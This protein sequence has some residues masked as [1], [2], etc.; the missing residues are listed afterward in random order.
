MS[1]KV[2]DLETQTKKEYKRKATPFCKENYIVARGWKNEGDA[3]C[4]HSYFNSA[5]E[6]TDMVIEDHIDCL[7]GHN[8]KFDMLWSWEEQ[9]IRDFITRGG[10]IWC[11]QYAEYLLRAHIK[12]YHMNSMDEIVSK[13]GGQLK[14]GGPKDLWE[15][16]YNTSEIPKDM[17]ID[18]LVGTEEEQRNGGDIGNT[19][20]IYLGQ[21]KLAKELNMMQIIEDRMDGLLATTEMEYNGLYVDVDEARSRTVVLHN[22]KLELEKALNEY[23]PKFED[24]EMVF[25]WN[26]PVHKSC[27]MFGGT[28]KYKKQAPYLNDDGEWARKK[29]T[30]DVYVM[31]DETIPSPPA[32]F[33][34]DGSP[35]FHEGAVIFKSGKKKGLCK[36]KKLKVDGELK[37]KY[38]EFKVSLK[39]YTEPN[40]AWQTASVDANGAPLYSMDAD[41]VEALQNRDIPFVK[42]YVSLSKLDK[43][44][45]YYVKLD[46]KGEPVGM[47]TCVHRDSHIIHHKINHTSTVTG[48][49]SS[50]DPNLQNIPRGDKSEIKRIFTSRFGSEGV[51]MECDYSQLEVVVQGVLSGDENLCNDLRNRVDFH[52]KRVSAA[53]HISYAD[54]VLWCKDETHVKYATW[55]GIRTMAKI[56]SFQRAYGAGAKTIADSTGMSLEEVE[57]L[58]VAEEEMYPGVVLFNDTVEQACKD[59]AVAFFDPARGNTYR[60]GY[61]IAPTG[62]RYSWRSW[63]APKFMQDRGVRDAFSP[64][65][66]KNY[67]VQGTGGEMVQ[68]IL[69]K[70]FRAYIKQ[71]WWSG[72]P[73][74]PALLVNTVHDC[75]WS[76][77]LKSIQ[78]KVGAVCKEV[79][80]SIP[81]HY[82]T[83]YDMNITVPFPVDVECGPN[84][85]ELHGLHD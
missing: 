84:M 7:V 69:G 40:E 21:L 81:E 56:F 43:E 15:A 29:E 75:K 12:K 33:D 37:V 30:I 85:Y 2:F 23:I 44:L 45:G 62:T 73:N 49:L 39:G 47:L 34:E 70:L 14:H 80:E 79:M 18:Y 16:G 31:V 54:A 24:P 1:W 76:D 22:K 59:S 58:I 57:A 51:M 25:N 41:T 64:P 55:K 71:G 46:N 38:Q 82:N 65:E 28:I 32:I 26:S 50:S 19:E 17:L 3:V 60:R 48:R 83:T 68:V 67:P 53:Q 36:T 77:L 63:D 52:C 9:S 78:H 11:T 6:V 20:L 35:V 27:L 74:A 8:I 72:I 4:S 13:Y 66:L 61:W 42:D 10:K 5:E